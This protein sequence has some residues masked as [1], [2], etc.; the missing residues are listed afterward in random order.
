MYTK[1]A[2][3]TIYVSHAN[4]LKDKRQ[5]SKSIIEK[6]KHRFNISIAEVD[7][8]E[9][10]KTLT[11]GIAVVSGDVSYL[12]DYISNVINY[13]EENIDADVVGYEEYDI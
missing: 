11:I 1:A 4:S 3:I 8:Q 7:T 10:V 6:T 13:I 12:K 9:M 2:K 5:V